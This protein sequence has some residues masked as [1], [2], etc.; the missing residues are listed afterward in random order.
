MV[1]FCGESWLSWGI[2]S[3]FFL[4]SF[5]H[6]HSLQYHPFVTRGF[7]LPPYTALGRPVPCML[8]GTLNH[9]EIQVFSGAAYDTPIPYY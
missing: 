6:M 8:A 5:I 4:P 2:G 1:L 3:K 9:E 7:S